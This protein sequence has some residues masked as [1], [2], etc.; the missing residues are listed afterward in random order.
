MNSQDNQWI[1]KYAPKKLEDITCNKKQIHQ[2][3]DWIQKFEDT[4]KK[5]KILKKNPMDKT[6]KKDLKST[7]SSLF[8][9]GCHGV[10]KT[11][12]VNLILKKMNYEI[13]KID[14]SYLKNRKDDGNIKNITYNYITKLLSSNDVLS[15]MNGYRQNKI[16]IVIDELESINNL[17][18]KNCINLL[19]KINEMNWISPVIFICNNQHNKLISNIKDH[20][21]KVRLFQPYHDEMKQIAMDIIKR[22]NIK[23]M[24]SYIVDFIVKKCQSDI[25]KM[26]DTLQ[27]IYNLL[28]SPEDII[29]DTHVKKYFKMFKT[30]DINIDI[31]KA[32]DNI[33]CNYVSINDSLKNYET[34]KVLIPLM[35]QYN[36][37]KNILKNMKD[38]N[39]E[40]QF[41]MFKSISES[42]MIGDVIENYINGY[43]KYKMYDIH[44]VYTCV[45][46]SK[47]LSGIVKPHNYIP[48]VF[49][50]DLNRT[51]TKKINK[52][53]IKKTTLCFTNMVA[54]DYIYINMII[55]TLLNKNDIAGCVKLLKSY[56]IKLEHI[57]SLL[58]IDKIKKDKI[59]LTIKQKKDLIKELNK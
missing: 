56:D 59:V 37:P 42:L 1:Y 6:K 9:S 50:T 21:T 39:K 7:Y 31:F 41:S 25:R 14:F 4:S 38:M 46:V 36:Y 13:K 10:G 55:K 52:N 18:E 5:M 23:I 32:T 8:V 47:K 58:K 30:K 11:L 28:E 35:V 3:I 15:M 54:T 2:I 17:N 16:A 29:S 26:I 20:S 44:G 22:E 48:S 34:D 49:A 19:L 43:Q 40:D 33:L 24:N 12:L 45:G 57:E 53:N 27:D 51:S